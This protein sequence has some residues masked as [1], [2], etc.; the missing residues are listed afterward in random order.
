MINKRLIR[1]NLKTGDTSVTICGD[2]YLSLGGHALT[3]TIISKEV[4][5]DCH[6]LGA[7]NK[8]VIATGLISGTTF[9]SSN[10]LS[11]GGKS[12][13]TGG[14]KESNAGGDCGIKLGKMGIKG[15][16]IEDIVP[17]EE[18]FKILYI[19]PDEVRIDEAG[20]IVGLNVYDSCSKLRERYGKKPALIMIGRAGEFR[21]P[22]AS[23]ALT[24]KDGLPGRSAGRGGMG[25]VMGSKKLK[26]IVIDDKGADCFKNNELLNNTVKTYAKIMMDNPSM[27]QRY[28]YYG[29]AGNLAFINKMLGLPTR[30][31][32]QGQ[33]EKIDNISGEKMFE[34][35]CARK[36]KENIPHACMPGCIVR[37]SKEYV[38]EDGK[39]LC[40]SF[41]YETIGLMGSNLDVD[42]LDE[43]A[44]MNYY[45]DD[46]GIDTMDA[47]VALGILSEAGV[48]S[49]GDTEEYKKALRQVGENTPLGRL[50]GSGADICGKAYG[51][52]RSPTVRKQAI[53]AYDPRFCKGLGVTYATSPM[54]ADHTAGTTLFLAMDHKDKEIQVEASK[55]M[56][57]TCML[58]DTLGLCFIPLNIAR[59]NFNLVEDMTEVVTGVRLSIDS[60]TEQS[61]QIL[62]I[63]REFNEGAG[64]GKQSNILPEFFREEPLLPSDEHF[65]VDKKAIQNIYEDS[66]ACET[67]E[68]QG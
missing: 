19:S 15:I 67:S 21:M 64:I 16:I 43:I 38:D 3:S 14:I 35:Q 58:V 5:P 60:L 30:N 33:Y 59:A 50:I 31:F 53:S 54:G 37:C 55:Q 10:R 68:K 42:D 8:L 6:P 32:L 51:I 26:A 49:F 28:P 22:I 40:Q 23:I 44:R 34:L 13:L 39:L 41:E 29:T 45:C 65:D 66:C 47:G 17:E 36:G 63:E 52:K 12:P 7:Y 9:S 25:A 18:D 46:I 48:I 4:A 1:V 11:I 57:R 24:D 27:S 2:D 61:E 62:K 56:Q 20:D